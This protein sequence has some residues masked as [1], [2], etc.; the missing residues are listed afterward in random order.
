MTTDPKQPMQDPYGL[1]LVERMHTEDGGLSSGASPYL[2]WQ[3]GQQTAV[4]DGD[5]TAAELRAIADHMQA[6]PTDPTSPTRFGVRW[7]S[8][9]HPQG[10]TEAWLLDYKGDPIIFPDR[11][12]AEEMAARMR[13]NIGPASPNGSTEFV[14]VEYRAPAGRTNA[15]SSRLSEDVE[16]LSF[17]TD[18]MIRMIEGWLEAH[19]RDWKHCGDGS[20][21]NDDMAIIALT[22]GTYRGMLKRWVEH[23][24]KLTAALAQRSGGAPAA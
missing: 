6:A 16:N 2:D 7:K 14:V 17:G 1:P 20:P 9:N 22:D 24:R 11:E 10:H 12:G 18:A 15:S 4:L 5:F 8:S 13:L 3:P 23:L 21:V 19:E